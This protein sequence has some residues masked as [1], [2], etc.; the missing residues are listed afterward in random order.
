METSPLLRYV[1][2]EILIYFVVNKVWFILFYYNYVPFQS[3]QCN[4]TI[5][6]TK[7]MSLT[8]PP[9]PKQTLKTF[10]SIIIIGSI[11][12][13][14]S[15]GVGFKS[16]YQLCNYNSN[17]SKRLA[18]EK[19][20]L[21]L[22]IVL[23][24]LLL[25]NV[26]CSFLLIISTNWLSRRLTVSSNKFRSLVCDWLKKTCNTSQSTTVC[27]KLGLYCLVSYPLATFS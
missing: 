7:S 20:I 4:V 2:F 15:T 11:C 21:Q 10:V 3:N 1:L 14:L 17:L 16:K 18:T 6:S 24:M 19:E 25:L 26:N 8:N 22:I 13:Y 23:F 27:N 9:N 12:N 5:K